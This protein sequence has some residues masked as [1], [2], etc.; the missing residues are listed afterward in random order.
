MYAESTEILFVDFTYFLDHT[1]RLVS[2]I[3]EHTYRHKIVL[4]SNDS[5]PRN[6]QT[7]HEIACFFFLPKLISEWFSLVGTP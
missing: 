1:L 3:Q 2:G 7:C 4:L 5:W 6:A